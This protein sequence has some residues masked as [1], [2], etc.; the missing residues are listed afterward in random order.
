MFI[1]MSENETNLLYESFLF[2]IA[3]QV[4]QKMRGEVIYDIKNVHLV[5]ATNKLFFLKKLQSLV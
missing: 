4:P 2:Y 5:S 1:V 3:F